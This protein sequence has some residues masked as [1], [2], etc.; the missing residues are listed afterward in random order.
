MCF[1]STL[2]RNRDK[3][4]PRATPCVF[5]GYSYG[6]K[7]YK[8]LNLETNQIFS[9][10]DVF[11]ETIFPY[12][13][14]KCNS[15][16]PLIFPSQ[17]SPSSSVDPFP[18]IDPHVDPSRPS[19]PTSI[20]PFPYIDPDVDPSTPSTPTSIDPFPLSPGSS[21][22]TDITQPSPSNTSPPPSNTIITPSSNTFNPPPRRSTKVHTQ[23]S[24]LQAY[25][26]N[27]A[28]SSPDNFQFCNYSYQCLY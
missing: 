15:D 5:L 22:P 21:H 20:D 8:L 2:K 17:T 24:Y 19:T 16:S 10:R 7:A 4:K 3:F 9:S 1:V 13:P 6:K 28:I 27:N 14:K 23:P 12:H 26:C 18:Y 11:H 25:E